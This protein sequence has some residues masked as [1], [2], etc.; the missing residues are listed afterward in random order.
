MDENKIVAAIDVGTTK[1]VALIG[2][3]NEHGS[4]DILGYGRTES[5]GM[6]RGAVL[7]IEEVTTSIASAVSQAE[8]EANMKITEAYVGIAGQHIRSQCFN[9]PVNRNSAN[10][11]IS[12]AEV[13][14][15]TNQMREVPREMGEEILHILPQNYTVD[16]ESD[17]KNPVGISG[18]QFRGNFHIVFGK[19]AAANNLRSC[20]ERNGI[21]VKGLILEPLASS[22]AVLTEDDKDLGVALVDIGGGTTDIA[23]FCNGRICYTSVIPCGGNIITSDIK[24][25]CKIIEKD[26]EDLKVQYGSAW[27][28]EKMKMQM[29]SIPG[30]NG[31]KPKEISVYN[32]AYI[33]RSR[34]EEL[35]ATMMQVIE[36][37]GTKDKLGA[38][39]VVTG[40]GSLLRNLPQLFSLRTGMD[41]RIGLPNKRVDKQ[42]MVTNLPSNATA[43]GLLTM[44]LEDLKVNELNFDKNSTNRVADKKDETDA[45]TTGNTQD[46]PAKKSEKGGK[47]GEK[48]KKMWSK[49]TDWA[50]VVD[51]ENV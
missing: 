51:D 6:K 22:T 3:K 42:E 23:I 27:A 43:I 7:N 28:T 50:T 29:V 38:G 5:R 11:A 9:Q 48:I 49:F 39:I 1:I 12:Q 41:V 32:L 33:I 37:S 14:A 16:N 15:L 17:I 36:V 26:A 20:V 35:I 44:G 31:M 24:Q 30:H 34:M 4:I 46:E 2:R 45:K 10:D 47:A 21:K 40:G 25:G 8:T 18:K 13:D 19:T